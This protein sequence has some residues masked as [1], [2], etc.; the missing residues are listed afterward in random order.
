[1]LRFLVVLTAIDR[2]FVWSRC[3]SCTLD[4]SS[5]SSSFPDPF[6]RW[7]LQCS[8][9]GFLVAGFHNSFQC[10][11]SHSWIFHPSLSVSMVQILHHVWA[12]E[13]H[14]HWVAFSFRLGSFHQR[15]TFIILLDVVQC[16]YYLSF[17]FICPCGVSLQFTA[18]VCSTKWLTVSHLLSSSGIFTTFLSLNWS[19]SSVLWYMIL[20]S[21]SSFLVPV[22][23]LWALY[24]FQ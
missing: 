17:K 19:L 7:Y 3:H 8:A 5:I 13:S 20:S 6:T 1:M 9:S 10:L 22:L 24:S 11:I 4:V 16:H 14:S 15:S 23:V 2:F 18:K 12:L 21:C